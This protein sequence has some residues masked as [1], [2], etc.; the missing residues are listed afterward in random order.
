MFFSLRAF[1]ET[2][3]NTDK[4]SCGGAYC[5]YRSVYSAIHGISYF[6]CSFDRIISTTR[7]ISTADVADLQLTELTHK[8]S[9]LHNYPLCHGLRDLPEII[10]HH[11]RPRSEYNGSNIHSISERFSP[12][13]SA[14]S[15][16][17]GLSASGL[18]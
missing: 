10:A 5:I 15:T 17:P 9:Y 1:D 11:T 13:T 6:R 8:Y 12:S 3:N 16:I 2:R 14:S 18:P 7:R 4:K